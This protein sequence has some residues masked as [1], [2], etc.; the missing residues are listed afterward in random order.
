MS[1]VEALHK[2]AEKSDGRFHVIHNKNE[3]NSFLEMR[4]ANRNLACGY[5]G[6]EGG[7]CLEGK[8]EN[9][10]GLWNAGVRM[11]GPTHFFDNELGGSAHGISGEGL[12]DFG[13]EVVKRMNELGMIIDVAHSS[14]AT[15]DD[16][17]DLTTKPVLTSHTGVKGMLNS[18]RNLSDQHIISIANTGGLIGVA[19]FAG[20]IGDES[21]ETIVKNMKYVKDL[22]GYQHVALGSDYDGSVATY[23]DCTG[24]SLLV[25]EMLKQGFSEEEIRGIMGENLKTFLLKNLPE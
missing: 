22:V 5:L 1:I 2:F 23:F 17:L 9:V 18:P 13:K 25:E 16:V 15:I 11:M 6:V 19:F 4:K 7:H 3:L 10:D 14:E 12:T 20:A 24:F 8:I 21:P